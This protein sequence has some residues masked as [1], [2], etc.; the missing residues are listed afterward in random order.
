[1]ARHVAGATFGTC[2]EGADCHA[3]VATAEPQRR[4]MVVFA[5]AFGLLNAA[6]KLDAMGTNK[7]LRPPQDGRL[8][9]EGLRTDF[10]QYR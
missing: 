9:A 8:I 7:R 2:L 3:I 10:P 4:L 1:M 5:F 6:P